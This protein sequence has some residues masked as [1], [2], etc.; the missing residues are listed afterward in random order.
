MV[1]EDASSKGYIF[2]RI[3]MISDLVEYCDR[4]RDIA[5]LAGSD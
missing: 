4:F 5:F 3:A 2:G 1:C